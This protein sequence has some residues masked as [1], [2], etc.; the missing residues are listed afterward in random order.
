MFLFLKMFLKF[1]NAI[2]SVYIW[3]GN[4]NKNLQQSLFSFDVVCTYGVYFWPINGSEI[5]CKLPYLH[6]LITNYDH[7]WACVTIF[8]QISWILCHYNTSK[9]GQNFLI[10][11]WKLNTFHKLWD[12][13]HVK[14]TILGNV[15]HYM[16]LWQHMKLSLDSGKQGLASHAK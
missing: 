12:Y 13:R 7:R 3:D 5:L 16:L 10:R 11:I 6:R 2:Y 8:G 1:V 14:A 9:Y 4:E 15:F